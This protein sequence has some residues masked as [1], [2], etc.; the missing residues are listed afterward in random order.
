ML[1]IQLLVTWEEEDDKG[2]DEDEDD[3]GS[4][5]E[6]SEEDGTDEDDV[7]NA[8]D[9]FAAAAAG[10][11]LA[12]GD[13]LPPVKEDLS[14]LHRQHGFIDARGFIEWL[15]DAKFSVLLALCMGLH[16]R[17]GQHSPL[18]ALQDDVLQRICSRLTASE[19]GDEGS[20]LAAAG[21]KHIREGLRAYQTYTYGL[22]CDTYKTKCLLINDGDGQ[23]NFE[24][25]VYDC[26]SEERD[27]L[28]FSH[29]RFFSG[30]TGEVTW[31]GLF[32][33]GWW[34]E[35]CEG[36]YGWDYPQY[37]QRD[38]DNDLDDLDRERDYREQQRERVSRKKIRNQTRTQTRAHIGYNGGKNAGTGGAVLDLR[39]L[40][41]DL[42]C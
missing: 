3:E 5:E 29:S 1:W 10:A 25:F 38:P 11:A 6:E 30:A 12:A 2:S 39:E 27:L 20:P 9:E 8:H 41:E 17:L 31:T 28:Y 13:T 23:I 24:K 15:Y 26:I 21:T 22:P 40:M 32:F 16:P 34:P 7:Q 42:F 37:M 4:A 33:P 19:L 14:E 35:V 18:A 36:K